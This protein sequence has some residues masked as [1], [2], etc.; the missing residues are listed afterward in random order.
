MAQMAFPSRQVLEL[1]VTH[2][3]KP[4]IY[5]SD[6]I[7]VQSKLSLKHLPFVNKSSSPLDLFGI[8]IPSS[9]WSED[10]DD[11]WWKKNLM[12][13][14]MGQVMMVLGKRKWSMERGSLIFREE[15]FKCRKEECVLF[16]IPWYTE[17]V[18]QR[19]EDCERQGWAIHGHLW[20]HC[21]KLRGGQILEGQHSEHVELGMDAHEISVAMSTLWMWNTGKMWTQIKCKSLS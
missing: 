12:D 3:C 8:H 18:W 11:G 1:S 13:N 5:S 4:V 20:Y 14:Q 2:Y 19:S 9:K 6:S 21:E 17:G 7:T 15:G 16:K 10:E